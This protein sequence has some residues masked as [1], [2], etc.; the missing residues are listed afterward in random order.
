MIGLATSALM[1]AVWQGILLAAVVWLG[2][3]L[4]PKTPAAV[5]F[6]IWF[7]VFVVVTA[8]P[9]A[10]LWPHA[11]AASKGTAAPWLML[12]AR[13][14][15]AIAAVWLLAS[16]V[17]AGTLIQ[18]A[19]RV[20]ALWKRATPVDLA[21]AAEPGV[22][23]RRARLCTSDEV[24]RPT[25][26]G[27]F[28]PK[29]LIPGWLLD[30]LTR[31]ELEQ[32]VLH[33]TGHLGRADDWMN[34]LQKI[35]LVVFPL[36]PA[37][38]WVERRLCFERELAVDERVL[39]SFAGKAGAATAYA[40]CL[41]N[42]AEHRLG[43]RGLALALGALG[44]ESE[45]GRRVRRILRR[46]DAMKPLHARLVLGGAMLGLVVGAAG[47]ERCPK[48]VGFASGNGPTVAR[49][50][51]G[52][53]ARGEVAPL[54]EVRRIQV[55]MPLPVKGMR[56]SMNVSHESLLTT[57]EPVRS[58]D[59]QS[60][61]S[62]PKQV[63]RDVAGTVRMVQTSVISGSR[64]RRTAK[65]ISDVEPS[66]PVTGEMQWV[67]VTSWQGADGSRM[68]LTTARPSTVPKEQSDAPAATGDSPESEQQ[69]PQASSEEVH[70]YAAVPVRGGWLI[71]QL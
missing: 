10:M 65:A 54:V 13:W 18:A 62:K 17:R 7:G 34:L 40:A 48:V 63:A 69:Q 29:I 68:V 24:D 38:A 50:D 28:S 21:L 5:R 22:G 12:D 16:L 71:L 11:A 31:A 45:L 3:R 53:S 27:F 6:A 56:I 59:T 39:R 58:E 4:L 66:Q 2:L 30:K 42:L 14:S 19:L 15:L 46:G 49:A 1:A 33:E 26:I 35:A 67:M 44:R 23:S 32:I 55:R 9:M 25:V 52:R 51:Q 41:T 61:E 8:L 36:N 60:P 70:P 64:S 47:L 20:R 43:R 37:L 57:R